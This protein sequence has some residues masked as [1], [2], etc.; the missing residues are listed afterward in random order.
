M[1]DYVENRVHVQI[2]K[3]TLS[4]YDKK[5][6]FVCELAPPAPAPAFHPFSQSVSNTVGVEE[7]GS[8]R[9]IRRHPSLPSA[10]VPSNSR[11]HSPF[12]SPFNM[13]IKR[14]IPENL[15]SAYGKQIV[16]NSV[17]YGGGIDEGTRRSTLL[18]PMLPDPFNAKD[19]IALDGISGK[20]TGMPMS[21][22][23][24]PPDPFASDD[25]AHF[26]SPASSHPTR[27]T[28]APKKEV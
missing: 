5:Y 13:P 10:I 3:Y 26:G 9:E 11:D 24:V 18:I 25:D 28:L 4:T 1:I 14:I 20:T 22:H 15:P 12:T 27:R 7:P 16:P 21:R 6:A 8:A 2:D 23:S 19:H 17:S